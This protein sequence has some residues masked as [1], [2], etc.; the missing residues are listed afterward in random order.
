MSIDVSAEGRTAGRG[1]SEV[2]GPVTL[3]NSF[4][5]PPERDE[6]F[7]AGMLFSPRRLCELMQP[8]PRPASA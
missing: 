2:A 7:L 3:I 6:V 5:V 8:L 4:L 1:E